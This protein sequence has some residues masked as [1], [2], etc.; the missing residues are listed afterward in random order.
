EG[1]SNRRRLYSWTGGSRQGFES[2]SIVKSAHCS[3]R[4][5]GS[6]IHAFKCRPGMIELNIEIPKD[7]NAVVLIDTVERVC[8]AHHLNCTLKGTLVRYQGSVHWH[9]KKDKLKGTL[10]ITWWE[11]KNRLWF[12]VADR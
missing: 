2:T 8:L 9:F 6:L 12:K 4:V 10:E 1:C 11:S 3:D 7:V 5:W